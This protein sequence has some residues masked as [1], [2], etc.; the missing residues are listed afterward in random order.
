MFDLYF[1][2]KVEDV[3][4]EYMQNLNDIFQLVSSIIQG[5][6]S[7]TFINTKELKR[8]TRKLRDESEKGEFND[9]TED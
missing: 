7:N 2:G 1:I 3:E 8:Y 9:L 5:H 4:K 6:R